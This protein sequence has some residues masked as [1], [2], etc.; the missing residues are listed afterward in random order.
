MAER[1]FA[2][3]R[4]P[5]FT[6]IALAV[7]LAL[8]LP[9]LTLGVFAFNAGNSIAVWQGFSLHWYSDAWANQAVKA[10][11]SRSLIVTSW[12]SAIATMAALGTTCCA[13]RGDML[14]AAKPDRI[15]MGYGATA[16]LSNNDWAASVNWNGASM[17]ARVNNPNVAR[18]YPKESYPFFMDPVAILTDAANPENAYKFLNFVMEPE[19]AAMISAFAR[20]ANGISG[21]EQ[22]MPED[23]RNAPEVL[24]PEAHKAAGHLL[25]TC[26]PKAQEYIIAI[27]T[28]LQK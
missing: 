1:S 2:L 12:A 26:S 24:L 7:F 6:A 22:F 21:S 5:G 20:Y 10:A 9:I 11:T 25:P 3:I 17:R 13:A 23:M 28:E 4:L 16:R 15:S 19:N 14:M 27:W 8:Y 18:G